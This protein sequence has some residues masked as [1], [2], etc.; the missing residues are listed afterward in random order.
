VVNKRVSLIIKS[1]Q[2]WQNPALA[3]SVSHERRF[4]AWNLLFNGIVFIE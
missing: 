2:Y 4:P 3:F 1:L